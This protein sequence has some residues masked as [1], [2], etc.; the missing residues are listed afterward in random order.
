LS[1]ATGST[2]ANSKCAAGRQY[3]GLHGARAAIDSQTSDEMTDDDDLA[4]RINEIIDIFGPNK[5]FY[6]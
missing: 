1:S 6:I 4:V 5:R 3:G 2:A